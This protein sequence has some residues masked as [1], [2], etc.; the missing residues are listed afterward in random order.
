MQ[1]TL[2]AT[3]DRAGSALAVLKNFFETELGAQAL[4]A[5][6]EAPAKLG[7]EKKDLD[8][9]LRVISIGLA[10]PGAI[11]ATLQLREKAQLKRRLDA[12]LEEM[13]AIL[14]DYRGDAVLVRLGDKTFDLRLVSAEEMLD[15]IAEEE[16]KQR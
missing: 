16:K 5:A 1:I 6:Q 4:P 8:T 12:V 9:T 2:E 10:M 7:E 13:R 3:G 14:L 11:L 15:A